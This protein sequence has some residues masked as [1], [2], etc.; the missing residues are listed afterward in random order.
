[1]QIR[2]QRRVQH[3]FDNLNI[4]RHKIDYSVFELIKMDFEMRGKVSL[5]STGKQAQCTYTQNAYSRTHTQTHTH[6]TTHTCTHTHTR[7][8]SYTHAH[9]N[10]YAHTHDAHTH[11]HTTTQTRTHTH[12][13]THIHAQRNVHKRCTTCHVQ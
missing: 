7:A 8:H 5:C 12:T 13:C 3:K 1:M 11:K 6:T 4:R 10:I 2:S 9:T